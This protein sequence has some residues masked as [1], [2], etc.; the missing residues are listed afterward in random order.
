[1]ALPLV[2]A[3][4]TLQPFSFYQEGAICR[5]VHFQRSILRLIEEFSSKEQHKAYERACELAFQGLVILAKGQHKC[6]VWVDLHIPAN[7]LV[8]SA[9]D[10]NGALFGPVV[11]QPAA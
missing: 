3:E 11:H 2:V 6:Q 5:G 9:I 7:S 4:N 10:P 1:M 8:V